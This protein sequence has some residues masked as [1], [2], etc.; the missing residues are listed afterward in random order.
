MFDTHLIDLAGTAARKLR[1]REETVAVAES[2]CGGLISASLL[3]VPGASAYFVGGVVSYTRVAREALLAGEEG[4]PNDLQAETEP[5][6]L[7]LAHSIA[8]KLQTTWAVAETGAAGPT[9]SRYGDP[10]GHVWVAVAGATDSTRHLLTGSADRP[11]NMVTFA[12]TA[13]ELLI[14]SL[15]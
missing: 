8:T 14:D 11:G 13:L 3:A 6:A 15:G 2:S 5:Y 10:A 12:A 9:G 1:A 4:V 7:Y